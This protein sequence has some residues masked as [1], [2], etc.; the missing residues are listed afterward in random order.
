MDL[1]AGEKEGEGVDPHAGH[2]L[3]HETPVKGAGEGADDQEERQG[4][5]VRA[6][7]GHDKGHRDQQEPCGQVFEPYSEHASRP[8]LQRTRDKHGGGES[9]PLKAI[10]FIMDGPLNGRIDS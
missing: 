2:V 5:Q 6:Q 1:C 7:G 4:H 9:V 8:F 10:A 3:R